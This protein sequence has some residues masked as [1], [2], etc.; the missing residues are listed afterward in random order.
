MSQKGVLQWTQY[1]A[2]WC[3]GAQGDGLRG[4]CV[5]FDNLWSVARE[6]KNPVAHY[7]EYVLFVQTEATGEAYNNLIQEMKSSEK[8]NCLRLLKRYFHFTL[9][10]S[11]QAPLI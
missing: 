1:R 5:D 9:V 4:L 3:T 7:L 2:L 6:V 8:P 11:F 10:K